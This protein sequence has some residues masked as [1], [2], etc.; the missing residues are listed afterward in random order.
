VI[1]VSVVKLPLKHAY[2]KHFE[3]DITDPSIVFKTIAQD[4]GSQNSPTECKECGHD[5]FLPFE[6]E[7]HMNLRHS[8]PVQENIVD[9]SQV[10]IIELSKFNFN[11][12]YCGLEI[13]SQTILKK[14]LL[15]CKILHNRSHSESEKLNKKKK[16]IDAIDLIDENLHASKPNRGVDD[17]AGNDPDVIIIGDENDDVKI[18]SN[19]V[20]KKKIG[21]TYNCKICDETFT[22]MIKF[23]NHQII[24]RLRAD[25]NTCKICAME[26]ASPEELGDHQSLHNEPTSLG[27]VST[28]IKMAITGTDNGRERNLFGKRELKCNQCNRTFQQNQHLK[29]HIFMHEISTQIR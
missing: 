11:C 13:S 10:E 25:D 15:Q 19:L 1:K 9:S 24:H 12:K 5:Y 20:S 22:R 29:S 26:F 21:K 16:R 27:E 3:D 23:K 14:H 17:N 6:L 28:A 18:L 2:D 4:E 7:R 8:P